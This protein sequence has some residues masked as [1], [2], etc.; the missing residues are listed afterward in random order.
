MSTVLANAYL[1]ALRE[2]VS[3]SELSEYLLLGYFTD[4]TPSWYRTI[5]RAIQISVA[6]MIFVRLG[7][8]VGAIILHKWKKRR[9]PKCVIQEQLNDAFEGNDFMLAQR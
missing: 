5:G 1:P 2:M 4:L 7:T 6:G 3:N 8:L 9:A